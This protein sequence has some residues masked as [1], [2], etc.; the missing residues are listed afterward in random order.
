MTN[1]IPFS[2]PDIS[3]S[4]KEA[5]MAV[6]NSGWITT[7][8]V[9]K[10]FER[11]IAEYCGVDKAVCL[12]SATAAMELTLRVLGIGEGD[13]VITS[14]YTFTAS[15]SVIAHVGAK[16][17]LCDTAPGSYLMDAQALEGLITENT[18]AIIPV[19]IGGLV[20]DYEAIRTVIGERDIAI[21]ADAAHSF[22]SQQNS[23]PS[24]FLADFTCFSFHAVKNLTTA[25]GGAV[26]WKT[27]EGIC[28]EDLYKNY[29]LLALHGQNKDALA[30]TAK[31][32]WEYDILTLG[33]KCNMTDIAA[34]FGLAQL[35]R[36]E[37]ML[38]RRSQ[39][40]KLYDTNLPADRVTTLK[41]S[42]ENYQTN[43]HLYM[44]RINGA[45]ESVRN[46]IIQSLADY[47][48]S[49]NVHFKPL[50]LLTAYKRMGFD[51][52]DFPNAYAQYCNEISLPLYSTMS[53]EDVLYVCNAF[54]KAL[55]AN[56]S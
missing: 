15:A 29:M 20:C 2:P 40:I 41:H 52:A 56:E 54:A 11:R 42:G 26:V 28:N 5:V 46:S 21:I 31:G 38:K 27:K 45:S 37:Q 48:V 39:L 34:A 53:D 1:P 7:G 8:P 23:K 55:Q 30:K 3:E 22:G 43:G 44:V 49:A 51:I 33:Y 9:T 6:L 50:P 19:D 25:E 14:A 17:I 35:D 36:Y 12:N 24:G 47:G 13:E 18:K 10:E 32:A 4:E 16:I